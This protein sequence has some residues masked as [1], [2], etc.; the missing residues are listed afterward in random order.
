MA[1]SNKDKGL[2]IGGAVIGLLMGGTAIGATGTATD[3]GEFFKF[4]EVRSSYQ[5]AAEDTGDT[6]E[7][8]VEE[9]EVDEEAVEADEDKSAEGEK[10][11]GEE[12]KKCSEDKKCAEGSC[13]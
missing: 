7:V 8:E 9:V 13:G 12:D 3:T 6:E 11:C 2:V 1:K 4:N 5:L 10:K